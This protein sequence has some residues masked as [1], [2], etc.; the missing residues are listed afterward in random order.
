MTMSQ[1]QHVCQIFRPLPSH[2][3]NVRDNRH[4]EDTV[5]HASLDPMPQRTLRRA[6]RRSDAPKDVRKIPIEL[7]KGPARY[8][9]IP[10]WYGRLLARFK[11]DSQFLRSTVQLAFALLCI[12]IGI[13]FHLFVQWGQSGGTHPFV[14][15][16]P[17]VE[18]F[19]P[20]SALISLSYWIQTGV[21][22]AVHPSGLFIFVA[23]VAMGLLFKKMSRFER[24]MGGNTMSARI[25]RSRVLKQEKAAGDEPVESNSLPEITTPVVVRSSGPEAG[26]IDRTRGA[27]V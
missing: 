16:P 25:R 24:L 2:A 13:E 23:I 1:L 4:A 27:L 22:N 9:S 20:I 19:L 10:E 6:R 3:E 8:S 21:I 5:E 15:R 26:E 14:A 18:G 11:E 7:R 12:W 17:G